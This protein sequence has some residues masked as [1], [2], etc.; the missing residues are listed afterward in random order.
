MVQEDEACIA[1]MDIQPV[2]LG[3]I[4]VITR[5]HASHL[6]ELAENTGAKMFLTI[7][8]SRQM[9]VLKGLEKMD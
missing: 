3:H 7:A 2:N 5:V 9:L 4:L 1:L 8:Q 6:S